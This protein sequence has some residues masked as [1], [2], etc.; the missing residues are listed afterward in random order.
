MRQGL[1]G[2]GDNGDGLVGCWLRH[3][4][5]YSQHILFEFIELKYIFL[6]NTCAFLLYHLAANPVKQSQLYDV[7]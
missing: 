3:H 2:A 7:K 1:L 6:G 4:R 5:F